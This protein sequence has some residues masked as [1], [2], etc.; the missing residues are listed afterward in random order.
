MKMFSIAS[1]RLIRPSKSE[2]CHKLVNEVAIKADMTT[3]MSM[4]KMVRYFRVFFYWLSQNSSSAK[5]GRG[6]NWW[7]Q[8]LISF[9]AVKNVRCQ[10]LEEKWGNTCEMTEVRLKT[11]KH[12]ALAVCEPNFWF[13]TFDLPSVHLYVSPQSCG[14]E[15]CVAAGVFFLHRGCLSLSL[16]LSSRLRHLSLQS[17]QSGPMLSWYL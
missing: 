4:T 10:R 12:G 5:S 14:K 16:L 7:E 3:T 15:S 1:H 17:P 6:N 9:V 8:H 11:N 13:P 2:I